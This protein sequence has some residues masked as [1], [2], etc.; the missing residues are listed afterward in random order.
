MRAVNAPR[1]TR[2]SPASCTLDRHSPSLSIDQTRSELTHFFFIPILVRYIFENYII[3]IL[4]IF[5]HI[6]FHN[7]STVSRIS[8][9]S[10]ITLE[11]RR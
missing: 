1:M 11:L 9:R 8:Q 6:N 2:S 10:G 5:L 7:L 4:Q 3:Q